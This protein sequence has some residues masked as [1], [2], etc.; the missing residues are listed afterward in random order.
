[1]EQLKEQPVAKQ[2]AIGQNNSASQPR[3]KQKWWQ[4]RHLFC[5]CKPS[6]KISPFYPIDRFAGVKETNKSPQGNV[7]PAIICLPTGG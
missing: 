2:A 7:I 1:L 5:F 4:A 3:T 6:S